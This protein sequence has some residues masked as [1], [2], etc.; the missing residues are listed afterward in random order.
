MSITSNLRRQHLEILGL[1]SEIDEALSANPPV[2]EETGKLL[3][4]FTGRINI[5]LAMEDKALYPKFLS[6]EEAKIREIAEDF[7]FEMGDLRKVFGDYH[8]KWNSNLKIKDQFGEFSRETQT[9]L[10]ALT[11]RIKREEQELYDVADRM[12]NQA[13]D[14]EE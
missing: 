2:I 1:I 3:A 4:A 8:N 6:S 7:I 10:G 13:V 11:K 5:H 9:I 12:I 14:V